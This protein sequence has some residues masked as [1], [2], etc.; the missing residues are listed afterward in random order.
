MFIDPDDL[1]AIKIHYKKV[2][3]HFIAYNEEEFNEPD[4]KINKDGFKELTTHMRQMT[5]G[6]YNEL[7][8]A[9]LR[10]DQLG[11]KTWNLKFFKENKLLRLIAKW[12]ATTKNAEE[13][14]TIVPINPQTI[15]T[16]APDIAE[17]IL[18]TY[19]KIVLI[20]DDE[21]KK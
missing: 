21:A 13:K 9:A 10:P 17:A 3:R 2:G 18:S 12:D 16:L 14:I 1:I 8:E 20:D 19:D 7:Q 6:L 15:S 11:N 5:W 4:S